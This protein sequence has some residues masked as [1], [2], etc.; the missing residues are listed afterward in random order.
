MNSE[1]N[2][3]TPAHIHIQNIQDKNYSSLELIQQTLKFLHNQ[4]DKLNAYINILDDYAL[5]R[6]KYVDE[7]ISS[8]KKLPLAGV[9][10]AVKDMLALKNHPTTAGSKTLENFSPTYNSTVVNKL[11]DAGAI[12]IG[13]TSCDEFAMGS[14]NEYAFTGPAHN[15]WDISR[16]PGGSSGGSAATVAARGVAWSIGTDT[17]G[18][19]RQPASFNGIYGMKPTYGRVSRF[20]VVAF[21]SSLE[22]VGPMAHNVYD[23]ALLMHTIAGHDKNDST[24]LNV[25]VPKYHEELDSNVKGLKIAIPANIY[26]GINDEIA[27]KIQSAI[28]LYKKNGADITENVEINSWQSAL[29]AYYLIAP[30]EASAN[31]SRY[32]GFR[33]GLAKL[34]ESDLWHRLENT[35][36]AG[37]GREVKRRILLGTYALSAGY[38]DAYY[39][40][41][42]KL[43]TLIKSDFNQVFDQFDVIMTPTTPSPA[44]KIGERVKDPLEMYMS[45]YYTIPINIAG[46][47]AIS[48]PCGFIDDLPVGLQIIGKDLEEQKLLQLAAFYESET[49]WNTQVPQ[50]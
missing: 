38:Y 45:D 48:I 9:P 19:I 36:G 6:A 16:V 31:L 29:P 43:R 8:G 25:D 20:G 39:N 30:S 11:E 13:K 5:A 21:A 23:L 2:N 24:T 47:P 34:D 35:R 14:S 22:Q 7:Q 46:N 18:S 12:I 42:L 44:F 33:Y 40:K 50:F 26:E 15:P 28:E 17:G 10:I 1:L 49:T 27:E 4:E 3:S 41:A 37:F 32:D